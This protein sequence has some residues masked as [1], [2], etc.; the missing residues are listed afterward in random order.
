[1]TVKIDTI[2]V[3]SVQDPREMSSWSAIPA[4]ICFAFEDAGVQIVR[5]G[6]LEVKEPPFYRWFRS[7]YC[8]L[9]LKWS[10]VAVEPYVLQHQASILQSIVRQSKAQVVVSILPEP[11][12]AKH[13]GMRMALVHECRNRIKRRAQEF[14]LDL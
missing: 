14:K 12:V 10:F 5:G 1:M 8:R 11:I 6:P 2:A 9:G 4:H 13:L 7:A 3:T